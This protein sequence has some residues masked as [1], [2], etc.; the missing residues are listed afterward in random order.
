MSKK[1]I[2]FEYI[3]KDGISKIHRSD[4][5][6]GKEKGLSVWDI[7]YANDVAFPVLPPNP[8][9]S[10]V[11]DYFYCLLGN[12]PVYLLEGEELP[13]KGHAGEPL[14]VNF[15]VTE[16]ITKDYD[17]L[18][19]VLRRDRKMKTVID[20]G[21]NTYKRL[22]NRTTTTGEL[23]IICKAVYDGTPLPKGHGRLIDA[24][25]FLKKYAKYDVK[26]MVKN[27]PTII[28]ADREVENDQN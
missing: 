8:S 22:R 6:L 12:K 7:V 28:E 16:E 14:L 4:E 24:D 19:S 21:E 18:K 17:Y 11:A 26:F 13:E 20:I 15:K 1:Y 10:C 3:P 23:D 5:I 2:R 27:T 25:L 9:E